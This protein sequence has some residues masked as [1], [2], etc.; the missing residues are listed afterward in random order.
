MPVTTWK[1]VDGEESDLTDLSDEEEDELEQTPVP[2][3]PLPPPPAPVA[4]PKVAKEPAAPA[5]KS[6]RAATQEAT[7]QSEARSNYPKPALQPPRDTSYNAY[8]LYEK[9]LSGHIDLNPEYQRDVVW[10]D[11]KQSSLIN[12]LYHNFHIPQ[13]LFSVYQDEY[14]MVKYVCIDG[15]QRLTS[16]F[17]FF[18]GEIPFKANSSSSDGS[19]P[20]N[21][22]EWFRKDPGVKGRKLLGEVYQNKF[23]NTQIACVEY[24]GLGSQHEREMFQRV[25]LGVSLGPADRLVAINGP[26]AD[27]VRALRSRINKTAGFEGYLDW[28][29][30][31][32]K[33]FQALAHIVYLSLNGTSPR[34]AEPT[35]NRIESFLASSDGDVSK[36]RREVFQTMDIFCRIASSDVWHEPLTVDLTPSEF[37]LSSYLVFVHRTNL[38]DGQLSQAVGML[39]SQ[40]KKEGKKKAKG[41]K[42]SNNAHFKALLTFIHKNVGQLLDGGN[43]E[44]VEADR[45]PAAQRPSERV[46]TTQDPFKYQVD[47]M[48]SKEVAAPVGQIRPTGRKAS[49]TKRKREPDVNQEGSDES[50]FVPLINSSKKMKVKKQEPEAAAATSKLSTKK[51]ASKAKTTV[52]KAPASSTAPKVSTSSTTKKP[53]S[54]LTSKPL[55]SGSSSH[56]KVNIAPQVGKRTPNSSKRPESGTSSRSVSLGPN[57]YAIEPNNH[58]TIPP[59]PSHKIPLPGRPRAAMQSQSCSRTLAA[60]PEP[61]DSRLAFEGDYSSSQ[62]ME[63]SFAA[64]SDQTAR[65]NLRNFVAPA[66]NPPVSPI[67]YANGPSNTP[68]SPNVQTPSGTSNGKFS[69]LKFSRNALPEVDLPFSLADSRARQGA[70][71]IQTQPISNSRD[72]NDQW[73]QDFHALN[74]LSPTTPQTSGVTSGS[75]GGLQSAQS[76]GGNGSAAHQ[77]RHSAMITPTPSPPIMHQQTN[78]INH[79]IANAPP[80][81]P[82]SHVPPREPRAH[83]TQDPRRKSSGHIDQVTANNGHATATAHSAAEHIK[84]AMAR[85]KR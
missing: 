65:M 6:N 28:G 42:A 23:K 5:R 82:R 13:I 53:V 24:S 41:E 59:V 62:N 14:G 48:E 17:R 56:E 19:A 34:K 61:A 15:K 29:K 32:G 43:L 30:A 3:V 20:G 83:R 11:A 44:T 85:H 70:P 31:R 25:Q 7:K 46:E 63:T 64:P 38:T 9:I 49:G 47:A 22:K 80:P 68:D 74:L 69:H 52:K 8:S 26:W 10:N 73:R 51:G 45:R 60:L 18:H 50:D 78:F 21:K 16:I 37:V 33:D 36:T 71:R 12:S 75:A 58:S 27:M 40:S 84:S 1:H 39:R 54:A 76:F 81:D 4:R 35:P 66:Q 57:T 72:S 55:A 67:M 77:R 79:P 2:V